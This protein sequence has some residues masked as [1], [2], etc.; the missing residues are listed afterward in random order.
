[1]SSFGL[2]K[3]IISYVSSGT[4]LNELLLLQYLAS[5]SCRDQD[6]VRGHVACQYCFSDTSRW[7]RM[8]VVKVNDCSLTHMLL[9]SAKEK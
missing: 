2:G 8:E 9:V 4:F 1:M 6:L 7:I 5:P 3:K